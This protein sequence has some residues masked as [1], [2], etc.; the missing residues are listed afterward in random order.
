MVG[1]VITVKMVALVAVCPFTVTVMAPVVAP[2][3][4]EVVMLVT[5]LAITVAE[6]S[7]NSTILLEGVASKFVPEIVTVVPTTPDNGVKDEIAGGGITVKFE[8]LVAV[9][10]YTVT[11]IVPVVA[12]EG[13][14][15]VI[16]VTLLAVTVAVVPLNF[17]V[18]LAGVASKFVP[19]IIT[20]VP[21]PPDAGVNEVMVGGGITVKFVALL[22]V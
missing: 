3:G 7:L 22:A 12:P 16:L 17:T 14:E 10:P 9:C 2:T 8:A 6:V 21:T 19:D 4:T 1:G 15:V 20:V 18:L 11:V 5:V 13:T